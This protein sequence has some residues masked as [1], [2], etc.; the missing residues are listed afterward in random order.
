MPVTLSGPTLGRRTWILFKVSE[1]DSADF[2][3]ALIV[4][5]YQTGK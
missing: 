4:L 3:G 2:G 5:K 1:F